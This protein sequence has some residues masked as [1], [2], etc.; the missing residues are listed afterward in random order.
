MRTILLLIILFVSNSYG[1]SNCVNFDISKFTMNNNA[2]LNSNNEAELTRA[3]MGQKGTIWANDK[4]DLEYDITIRA[5]IYLGNSDRGADGIAFVLQPLSVNAGSEG[6]GLGY[7]GI[8]P[9]LAVEFDTYYNGSYEDAD[10]NDHVALIKNGNASSASAHSE[11]TSYKS[12]PNLED[13]KWHPLIIDW[14]AAQK[15]LKVTLDGTVVISTVLDI[16]NTIFSGIPYVYWGFTAATGSEYNNQKVK[17]DNYCVI[18]QC[19]SATLAPTG[20]SPQNFCSTSTVANLVATG[21]NIKWYSNAS[22]GS[23][24]ALTTALANTTYY[25]SQSVGNCQS[26]TRLPVM[27]TLNNVSAPVSSAPQIF[28][29]SAKVSNLNVSGNNIKWYALLSGGQALLPNTDLVDGVTYYATQTINS[30]ESGLRLSVPVGISNPVANKV[31]DEN[32]CILTTTNYDLA[33]N[34]YQILGGQSSSVYN[35]A[36][37]TSQSDLDDN[38]KA[39]NSYSFTNGTS[40]KLF[41]KVFLV[42]LPSCYASTFF[43]ITA[44]EQ[45]VVTKPSD[46]FICE[47]APYD[48]V[49]TFNLETKNKELVSSSQL[50]NFNFSYFLSQN[51][52]NSNTNKLP[53]AYNNVSAQETIYVRVENKNSSSCFVTS[54][55]KIMLGKQTNLGALPDFNTC[56]D[57]SND[58]VEKFDLYSQNINVLGS[59]P[60]NEFLISYHL[61]IADAQSGANSL[62]QFYTN[63]LIGQRIYVK[64]ANVS[65]NDCYSISYFQLVVKPSP[66]VILKGN[67]SLCSN[68][69]VFLD[70]GTGFDSYLWSTGAKTQ[71]IKV[72]NAGVYSIEVSKNYN[73]LICNTSKSIDVS[74][75]NIAQISDVQISDWTEN[76]NSMT[77]GVNGLGDYEYSLDNIHFQDSPVFQNMQI[78]IYTVYVRDKNGCGTAT[79]MVPFLNYPN[80]FTPNGDGINDFWKIKNSKFEPGLKTYVFDRYDKLIAN[81]SATSPGW[82]GKY[83]HEIMPSTDYWFL[84]IREDGKEFRGHF[85]LKR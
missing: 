60:A 63:T 53:F 73:G 20:A 49:E 28:C 35:I 65:N 16:K 31:S 40:I 38:I 43:T 36:Y 82:D 26:T 3:Q 74:Y 1:Q 29:K 39:I 19:G 47:S 41:A 27:V 44:Y 21:S 56:D 58:G 23:P 48:G 46:Y 79:K 6:G 66:T 72:T 30:C 61:N 4:L 68:N 71:T 64:I 11:I 84:V 7:K 83:N 32:L 10:Y 54:T 8:V 33:Q 75:S 34:N 69:S 9:S 50:T 17:I 25:A 14:N 52:A 24:L 81:F 78:G 12:L 57:S 80:Y 37:Y 77:I 55:F 85:A 5:Q 13:G 2:F 42:S 45:P 76:D 70:A 22:G 59:L 62:N 51:D 15:K 18:T 67:K